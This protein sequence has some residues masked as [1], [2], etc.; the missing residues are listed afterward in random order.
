MIEAQCE[1]RRPEG[2][3]IAVDA[4]QTLGEQILSIQAWLW[5]A[6]RMLHRLQRIGAQAVFALWPG[7]PAL[8]TPSRTADWLEV[9]A[10]RLEAWKGSAA[11]AGA[12]RALEF[13][14]RRGTLGWIYP[15]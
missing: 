4:P 14:T 8:R 10:G 1:E 9:A 13:V 5:P 2:A 3:Q 12:R 7:L 6:H 15:S 11:R